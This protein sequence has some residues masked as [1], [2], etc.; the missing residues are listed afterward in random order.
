MVHDKGKFERRE[1]A[2]GSVIMREGEPGNCAYLIQSGRVVVFNDNKGRP[3]EL[4]RLDTGEI[5]GEMALAADMPRTATVK[6]LEDCTLIVITREIL[7]KKLA[8]SDS[9]IQAIIKMMIKRMAASNQELVKKRGNIAELKKSS[10]EI[11]ENVARGLTSE[12]KKIFEENVK[13]KLDEFIEAAER[14]ASRFAKS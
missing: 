2:K 13:T 9:T 10:H 11:Y 12:E 1:I 8:R 6:A 5:F 3:V 4:A 14:F 7:D